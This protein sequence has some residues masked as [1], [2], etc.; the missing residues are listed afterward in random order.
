MEASQ[1]TQPTQPTIRTYKKRET[2][3]KPVPDGVIYKIESIL[4]KLAYY[5]SSEHIDKRMNAHKTSFEKYKTGKGN[6]RSVYKVMEQPDWK[7]TI[8]ERKPFD[9]LVE[10]QKREGYY[11]TTFPC[12]N[13]R[14]PFGVVSIKEPKQNL[15]EPKTDEQIYKQKYNAEYRKRPEVIEREKARRKNPE[16]N[17][18]L[19]ASHRNYK[20]VINARKVAHGALSQG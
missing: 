19:L 13:E 17:R 4:A 2:L 18:Q 8:L 11:I 15:K 9:S 12:V 20:Q 5:G 1:L 14:S 6:G 10:L 16:Y 3:T 7:L